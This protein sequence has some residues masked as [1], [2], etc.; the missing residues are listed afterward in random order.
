MKGGRKEEV[1]VSPDEKRSDNASLSEKRSFS[2]VMEKST[3][4]GKGQSFF[5]DAKGTICIVRS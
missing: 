1:E 4:G 5:F 2:K 3:R